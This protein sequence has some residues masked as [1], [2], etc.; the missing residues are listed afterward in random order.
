MIPGHWERDLVI[1]KGGKPAVA[2]LVERTSRFLIL[3]PLTGRDPLTVSD[4]VISAVGPLPP[5]IKRSPTWDCGAGNGSAQK[6]Y[7]HRAAGD[8]RSPALTMGA[9]SNDNINR[10]VREYFPKDVEITSDPH[11]LA[12]VA[13]EINDRRVRSTT[14][15]TQRS[16][17]RAP[18]NGCFHR[19][20]LPSSMQLGWPQLS[21]GRLGLH[22]ARTVATSSF[23]EVDKPFH[24]SLLRFFPGSEMDHTGH[25]P[26]PAASGDGHLDG[27]TSEFGIRMVARGVAKQSTGNSSIAATPQRTQLSPAGTGGHRHPHGLRS[28]SFRSQFWVTSAS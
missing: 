6:C 17:R 12:A 10:I 15:D 18:R 4:A 28:G 16:L 7:G 21:R 27:L 11:Y 25:P 3:V 2:T 5:T 24:N 22:P 9:G 8:P 20:N 26:G 1:G 13:A 14:G 19:L 23:A